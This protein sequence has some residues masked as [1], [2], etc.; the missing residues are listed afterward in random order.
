[1]DGGRPADISIL[2]HRRQAALKMIGQMHD[3]RAGTC[4]EG[5]VMAM[6]ALRQPCLFNHALEIGIG[7]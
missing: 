1:M 2:I 4:G 7:G 5:D 6:D 3:G